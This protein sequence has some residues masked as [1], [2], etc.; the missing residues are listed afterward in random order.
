TKANHLNVLQLIKAI[1]YIG[2]QHDKLDPHVIWKQE[3]VA[4]L[5]PGYHGLNEA[6]FQESFNVGSFAIGKETMK[7]ADLY[8]A[9]NQTYCG[10]ICAE[11]MHI[12]N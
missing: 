7:L 3:T 1:R 11:Y 4:D 8:A 2:H 5:D 12:T 9:L 6:D 10:S